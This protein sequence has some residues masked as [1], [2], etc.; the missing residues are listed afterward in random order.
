[1]SVRAEDTVVIR[2]IYYMMAYAFRAIDVKEFQKLASES[3]EHLDDLLAA[4]LNI[5]I[6]LQRKRGFER[7]YL[8]QNEDIAGLRGRLDLSKTARLIMSGKQQTHCYFDEFNEDTYKNRILKRCAEILLRN[9]DVD[10]IRHRDLKRSLLALRDVSS[11]DEHRIDWSRL[12]YHRNNASYRMLMNVCYLIIDRELLSENGEDKQL[13]TF[14]DVRKLSSLYENFVLEYYRTHHP[15]LKTDARIVKNGIGANAP[16]FLP[17]LCTDITLESDNGILII[18]TK[19]Y[20]RILSSNYGHEILSPAHRN[21]IFS[22]VMHESYGNEKPVQGMLLYALTE[23]EQAMHES[24][25]ELDHTFHCF[26]LNLGQDFKDI[27]KQLD[28][29]AQF[30]TD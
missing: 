19:C 13:A 7:N 4:I 6:S 5:G 12:K 20:G 1:M 8:E 16:V 23:H 29:I 17:S 15:E 9:K 18:D 25:E 2:N 10:D 24:W 27:A 21:Q 22:Y 30:I 3:F 26:T 14:E 11:I 28:E